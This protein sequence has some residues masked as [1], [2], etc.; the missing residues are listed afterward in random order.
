MSTGLRRFHVPVKVMTGME[1]VD[2]VDSVGGHIVQS[3]AHGELKGI[4]GG[5]VDF[6]KMR[7]ARK[8]AEWMRGKGS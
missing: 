2:K 4:E 6:P 5:E 7:R 1:I 3:T 8:T